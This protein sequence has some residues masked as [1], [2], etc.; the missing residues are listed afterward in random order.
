MENKAIMILH[1]KNGDAMLK[2]LSSGR[3]M[4]VPLILMAAALYLM[5]TR[6]N[7]QDAKIEYLNRQIKVKE[8]E[9]KGE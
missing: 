6:I 1:V 7:E 5:Y 2:K 9:S 8:L 4:G 3:S